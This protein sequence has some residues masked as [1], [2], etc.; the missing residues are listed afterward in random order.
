MSRVIAIEKLAMEREGGLNTGNAVSSKYLPS[1]GHTFT[2][3]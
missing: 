1:K 3:S 2:Q